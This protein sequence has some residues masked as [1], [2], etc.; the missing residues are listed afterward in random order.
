MTRYVGLYIHRGECSIG[1]SGAVWFK[2]RHLYSVKSDV[3][4]WRSTLTCYVK[5]TQPLS[6]HLLLAV[7]LSSAMRQQKVMQQLGW[8]ER[9]ISSGIPREVLI[10]RTPSFELSGASWV[11]CSRFPGYLCHV[12]F[13]KPVVSNQNFIYPASVGWNPTV[14]VQKAR[15]CSDP[16][17]LWIFTW[18]GLVISV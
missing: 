10:L 5:N 1:P 6:D 3:L 13:T 15:T 16:T 14:S 9:Q 12:W 4:W 7:I 17:Q 18:K 2:R 11:E 8:S